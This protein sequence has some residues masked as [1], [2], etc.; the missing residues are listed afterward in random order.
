[1]KLNPLDSSLL[2]VIDKSQKIMD[3]LYKLSLTFCPGMI[4]EYTLIA[5]RSY[6]VKKEAK[7]ECEYNNLFRE[8][9]KLPFSK[10]LY[11]YSTDKWDLFKEQIYDIN[12]NWGKN[13][14]KDVV[15]PINSNK[16]SNPDDNKT[17]SCVYASFLPSMELITDINFNHPP[18]IEIHRRYDPEIYTHLMHRNSYWSNQGEWR[19]FPRTRNFSVNEDPINTG[20]IQGTHVKPYTTLSTYIDELNNYELF[21]FGD[22]VRMLIDIDSAIKGLSDAFTRGFLDYVNNHT[23]EFNQI[24]S[25][26]VKSGMFAGLSQKSAKFTEVSEDELIESPIEK[27]DLNDSLFFNCRKPSEKYLPMNSNYFNI[28]IYS[29]LK[30]Y[31]MDK[32]YEFV[33]NLDEAINVEVN[34]YILST[35][36]SAIMTT[37]AW[38][39]LYGGNSSFYQEFTS[40]IYNSVL[41]LNA[42]EMRLFAKRHAINKENPYVQNRDSISGRTLR[43]LTHNLHTLLT[44]LLSTNDKVDYMGIKTNSKKYDSYGKY[45]KRLSVLVGTLVN[46]ISEFS[47]VISNNIKTVVGIKNQKFLVEN[48][49]DIGNRALSQITDKG[50]KIKIQAMLENSDSF[51]YPHTIGEK[52]NL[53]TRN[54]MYTASIYKIVLISVLSYIDAM[55]KENPNEVDTTYIKEDYYQ[56]R[57]EIAKSRLQNAFSLLRKN[58]DNFYD[59]SPWIFYDSFP[60]GSLSKSFIV[61]DSYLNKKDF[62]NAQ[63]KYKMEKEN[64]IRALF[65]E[66]S[67]KHNTEYDRWEYYKEIKRYSSQTYQ[68][69]GITSTE[70]DDLIFNGIKELLD[71]ELLELHKDLNEIDEFAINLGNW[72]ENFDTEI[73]TN[74]DIKNI[75]VDLR[76]NQ[77]TAMESLDISLNLPLL[78]QSLENVVYNKTSDPN[79]KTKFLEN[80]AILD[81]AYYNYMKKD[82]AKYEK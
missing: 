45:N 36:I 71:D 7:D 55:I 70:E 3:S 46:R 11:T 65:D 80:L 68:F 48:T 32:N 24:I 54:Y 78:L 56:A 15:N 77:L 35:Q 79:K 64:I 2:N 62:Y 73:S 44:F 34:K 17:L 67:K 37:A 60:L 50:L 57:Y 29:C 25:E 5:L 18:R 1:M 59:S 9:N 28:Y 53:V 27:L 12:M 8:L 4:E 42:K 49:V 30:K 58:F 41:Q 13:D 61:R 63:T 66:I 74:V 72:K 40:K 19:D 6:K 82:I 51:K 23:E 47:S 10:L 20:L 43:N 81:A 75:P 16:G 33:K 39:N 69:I 21:E 22:N 31:D 38:Y 76:N 26:M 52:D 14:Y